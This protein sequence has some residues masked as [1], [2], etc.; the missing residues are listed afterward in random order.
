MKKSL[1]IK[2]VCLLALVALVS[3]SCTSFIMSGIEVSRNPSKAAGRGDFAIDVKV[4][5]FLG[6]SA[7]PNFVNLTAEVTDPKVVDAIRDE[8]KKLGGTKAINVK[9][10]YQATIIDVILN[11][12]TWG[13]YAPATAHVTGT[14]I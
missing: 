4:N 1:L 3:I 10:V 14:V 9:I 13:I 8:I 7:G 5:K 12:V 6:Y 2:L 11:A